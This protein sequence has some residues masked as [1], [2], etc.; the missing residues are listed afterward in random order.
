MDHN[1]MNDNLDVQLIPRDRNQPEEALLDLARTEATMQ[2][3]VL[4]VFTAV[5][6]V[7]SRRV[8]L[9]QLGDYARGSIGGN[10]WTLPGGSVDAGEHCRQA[11]C[12][13]ILE[14]TGVTI[15]PS[16]LS[17][18]A[19]IARP[20][21]VRHDCCGEISLLFA[22]RVEQ[23]MAKASPPETLD[24]IW[25]E[26]E[27]EAWLDVP[28]TGQGKHPLQPL[29]RHWIYWCLLATER[30]KKGN[31]VKFAIYPSAVSLRTPPAIMAHSLHSSSG[32]SHHEDSQ[33]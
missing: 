11:A 29:R 24:V 17:L 1:R 8:L 19:W 12:R 18:A 28:D 22:A 15:L 20:Y 10:P 27:L 5:I 25:S 21:V 32:H 9:V 16:Q 31:N 14:E 7:S 26:F 13:E 30:I 3:R 4:S 33:A 6:D 23:Q 2:S